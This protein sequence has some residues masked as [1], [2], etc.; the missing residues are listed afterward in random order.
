MTQQT[1]HPVSSGGIDKFVH[2][3]PREYNK[4]QRTSIPSERKSAEDVDSSSEEE[5][6][7]FGEFSLIISRFL[8]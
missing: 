3:S 5:D 2:I 1:H 6:T 7:T 4:W 8:M